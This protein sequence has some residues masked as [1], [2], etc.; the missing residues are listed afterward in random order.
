MQNQFPVIN[1]NGT[2]SFKDID[3]IDILKVEKKCV[4]FDLRNERCSLDLNRK[5]SARSGLII[6]VFIYIYIRIFAHS[7]FIRLH[8]CYITHTSILETSKVWWSIRFTLLLCERQLQV[9]AS[10]RFIKSQVF[11]HVKILVKKY[12]SSSYILLPHSCDIYIYVLFLENIS[13]NCQKNFS[14]LIIRGKTIFYSTKKWPTFF[15]YIWNNLTETSEN[16]KKVK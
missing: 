7:Q 6:K 16:I 12:Y 5:S 14:K 8:R 11:I 9:S 13:Q 1:F 10:Y 4:N 15:S 3:Y 2:N